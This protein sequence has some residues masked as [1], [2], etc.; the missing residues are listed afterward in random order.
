MAVQKVNVAYTQPYNS[1]AYDKPRAATTDAAPTNQKVTQIPKRQYTDATATD[2]SYPTVTKDFNQKY[3]RV[4]GNAANANQ[5]PDR[6][7]KA[8]VA[9]QTEKR[10]RQ[11]IRN[12][13][14]Y[15]AKKLRKKTNLTQKGW[16]KVKVSTANAWIG[17]WAMFWYLTFQLPLAVISAAALGITY[18]VYQR[19][20]EVDISDGVFTFV[21]SKLVSITANTGS[22]IIRR[23]AE[24]VFNIDFDPS[25][26]FITPFALI[27]LLGLMQLIISW[28]IYSSL[29]IKSLSGKAAG[30]KGITFM[31]AGVG[32][33]IPVLNMFP[34]IFI[35]MIVVWVH[36]K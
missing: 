32:Y 22:E 24:I 31:L 8:S 15:G 13:A 35:W 20:S 27:F 2:P 21:V 30:A 26:L 16:T 25:L 4:N 12:T 3:D 11:A 36:P 29:G 9:Y 7:Q 28:F 5:A 10:A 17:G 33:A 34:L 23:I 1:P 19:L 6:T 18:A 14:A